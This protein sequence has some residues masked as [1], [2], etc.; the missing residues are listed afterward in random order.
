MSQGLESDFGPHLELAKAEIILLKDPQFWKLVISALG[1]AELIRF[2]VN[3]IATCV[4][5]AARAK[6]AGDGGTLLSEPLWCLQDIIA[7]LCIVQV[8]PNNDRKPNSNPMLRISY[9][10]SR[11]PN[12]QFSDT[13][14]LLEA[15]LEDA[16]AS[17]YRQW[18]SHMLT[19][20][21]R[22]LRASTMC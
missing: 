3:R 15:K 9:C 6:E 13:R 14:L 16:L 2:A 18:R 12:E 5:H 4:Y 22:S 19:E 10:S 8:N 7:E 21:I 20:G 1:K 11:Q 17:K